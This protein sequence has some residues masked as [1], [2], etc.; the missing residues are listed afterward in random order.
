MKLKNALAQ[1]NGKLTFRL[2]WLRCK[3]VKA[4]PAFSTSPSIKAKILKLYIEAQIL[5]LTKRGKH[6]VDH[7]IPLSHPYVCG[8]HTIDNLQ[9]LSKTKNQ[10]KGNDFTP[11]REVDGRK[12]Y[13]LERKYSYKDSKIPSNH[14]QTKKTPKKIAKKRLKLVGIK[15]KTL[16]KGKKRAKKR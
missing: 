9:I 6:E 10:N 5:N 15:L 11:Y 12:Y 14:N 1:K 4:I 13:Y 3:K 7:I 16:K 2:S 8:L